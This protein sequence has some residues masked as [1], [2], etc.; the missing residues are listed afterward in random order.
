MGSGRAGKTGKTARDTGEG[1]VAARRRRRGRPPVHEEA[2][3]KV[4][5]VLFNRQ[6]VFLDRLAANIRAQSGAAISRAQLI[7]SLID[8]LSEGDIDLTSATSEA[9]LKATLLARLGRYRL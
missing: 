4:T 2:W 7:R 1:G 6:I 9:D 5:V 8:A 3:T